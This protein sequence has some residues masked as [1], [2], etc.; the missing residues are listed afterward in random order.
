MRRVIAGQMA[1]EGFMCE[2][3]CHLNLGKMGEKN[4]PRKIKMTK[5][6]R[7]K[8][9]SNLVVKLDGQGKGKGKRR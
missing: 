1:L 7:V 6:L 5:G 9:A 3:T 4:I 8:T 2:M